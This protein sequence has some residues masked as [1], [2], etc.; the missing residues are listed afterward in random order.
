MSNHDTDDRVEL[1]RRWCLDRGLWVGPFDEVGESTA[2]ALCDRSPETLR[3]WRGT[4]RRL[5][6]RKTK[7]GWRYALCDLAEFLDEDAEGC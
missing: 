3:Y 5:P 2:A 7:A 6:C 4:D 1:L